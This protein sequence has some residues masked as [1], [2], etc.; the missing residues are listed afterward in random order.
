MCVGNVCRLMCL[1]QVSTRKGIYHRI[2]VTL[3]A[4]LS[5]F[6]SPKVEQS[7]STRASMQVDVCGL[8][9]KPPNIWEIYNVQYIQKVG[10]EQH[11]LRRFMWEFEVVR[12]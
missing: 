10:I 11:S 2:P 7:K 4:H 12:L 8:L 3:S 5:H 9:C 1:R 6:V